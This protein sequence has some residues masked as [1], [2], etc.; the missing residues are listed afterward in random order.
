ML[1]TWIQQGRAS[2]DMKMSI[3][4]ISFDEFY[5]MIDHISTWHN[6]LNIQQRL[7]WIWCEPCT[8]FEHD[9]VC[10]TNS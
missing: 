7:A 3:E 5:S 9:A 6:E 4:I 2:S 10:L 1:L 8:C